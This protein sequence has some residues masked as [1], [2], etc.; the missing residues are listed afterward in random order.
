MNLIAR[1]LLE[2][3]EPLAEFFLPT[4]FKLVVNSVHFISDSGNSCIRTILQCV[5]SRAER[6]LP[7]LFKQ[8]K[9]TH[10]TLRSR[11]AEYIL[12]ILSEYSTN[13]IEKYSEQLVGIVESGLSD[14]IPEVRAVSRQSFK[15]LSNHWQ[16][17]AH[18]LLSRLDSSVQKYLFDDYKKEEKASKANASRS[19]SDNLPKPSRSKT[20]KSTETIKENIA[21]KNIVPPS[22]ALMHTFPAG[23]QITRSNSGGIVSSTSVS[24]PTSTRVP[25]S[26]DVPVNHS[27]LAASAPTYRYSRVEIIPQSEEALIPTK[28]VS[29]PKPKPQRV[30]IESSQEKQSSTT[31]TA[32]SSSSS[33]S[34]SSVSFTVVPPLP[35]AQRTAV[36]PPIQIQRPPSA[37][38][39]SR[40]PSSHSN[41]E[42][43]SSSNS[44]SHQSIVSLSTAITK[45]NSSLWST[46]VEGFQDLKQILNSRSH[47]V[48]S[49]FEKL[50]TCIIQH[51][52]DA[53]YRVIQ[54][55][56][57][58]I[59]VIIVNY[60]SNVESSNLEKILSCLLNKS[61][62]RKETVRQDAIAA[63]DKFM[64]QFGNDAILTLLKALEQSNIKIKS[65]C[66]EYLASAIPSST[67][68]FKNGN[69]M[70]LAMQRI[71]PLANP[72]EKVSTLGPQNL[73]QLRQPALNLLM[74]LYL[75]YKDVFFTQIL[76]L[77]IDLQLDARNALASYIPDVDQQLHF[78]SHS[79]LQ[80]YL[81]MFLS[82][83]HLVFP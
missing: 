25:I 71:I 32:S 62:D 7:E 12:L 38:L 53:H 44:S 49:H 29:A 81:L 10:N 41:H 67:S 4:L 69:Q 57:E 2:Q 83:N 5:S 56:L 24:L 14:A 35:S 63:T 66:L 33:T 47:E 80:L 21:T 1:V 27:K 78:F 59:K 54:L 79:P 36:I 20:N 18:S 72:S 8:T 31:T 68:F 43:K 42:D 37:S 52:N 3:F 65:K 15:A 9:S 39:P 19:I 70:R 13:A 17:L 11:S 23:P 77:P 51:T 45:A 74:L 50:L 76:L 48:N 73:Q 61:T 40:P 22:P 82:F 75:H 55:A 30:A 46:R 34:N 58:S 60:S 28:S 6:I 16:D 26:N 64:E